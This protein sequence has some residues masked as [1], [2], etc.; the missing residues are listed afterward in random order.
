MNHL[1][2]VPGKKR[3]SKSV[4]AL[5]VPESDIVYLERE[6]AANYDEAVSFEIAE[7]P[8]VQQP[9]R[10]SPQLKNDAIPTFEI[11]PDFSH[12]RSQKH[13]QV[14][15]DTSM[16]TPT[17]TEFYI[18]VATPADPP[19]MHPT[20]SEE[21]ATERTHRVQ[22]LPEQAPVPCK[23]P[24]SA[25]HP[26]EKGLFFSSVSS[27]NTRML[28]SALVHLVC[29]EPLLSEDDLLILLKEKLP[30]LT[31]HE[32]KDALIRNGLDTDYQRF[33]AYMGG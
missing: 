26:E 9:Q 6:V 20:Q 7:T 22:H 29:S 21:Q 25:A 10:S 5:L 17:D 1:N 14:S 23:T 16:Q 33:R 8:N 24:H 15:P 19:P 3:H 12:D 13:Y 30:I 27:E 11:F 32:L 28:D 18:P 2:S 31:K 4:D